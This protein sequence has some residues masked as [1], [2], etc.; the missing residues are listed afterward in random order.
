MRL[1]VCQGLMR[2]T[3]ENAGRWTSGHSL[4][5][6]DLI[7]VTMFA[8]SGRTYEGVVRCLGE[9]AFGEQG[10][11]LNRSLF[12]DMID[13]H[14]VSLNRE[15]AAER[16]GQHDLHSR[17]L[18]AETQRRFP[19]RFDGPPPR[20]KVTNEE[21][22]AL[23]LLFGKSGSRSW[24][25]VPG[26]DRR[27]EEVKGCWQ[28]ESEQRALL[29]WAAWVHKLSNEMLHPSALS[30]GRLGSPTVTESGG[31][32]WQFGSTR[33]LLAQALHG[34][35][36]TFG[37]LVGLVIELFSPEDG[38]ELG[39]RLRSGDATFVRAKQWEDSDVIDAGP[40]EDTPA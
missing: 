5:T 27:V 2:W 37:Q 15:L 31:L 19:E 6:A 22:K 1:A 32:Q 9:S 33:D 36:F 35:F 3:F 25:G 30:L 20:I 23:N 14:W 34:A 17:L 4:D 26:L 16:L 28:T 21:R 40:P 29:W 13:A 7:I 24:T 11:M 38:E 8:R 12:E 18:R 10:L 39:E